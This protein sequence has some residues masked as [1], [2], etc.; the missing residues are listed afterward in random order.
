M[1]HLITID[2]AALILVGTHERGGLERELMDAAEMIEHT[3]PTD[4]TRLMRK[5]EER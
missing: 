3:H 4:I 1:I 2:D 5:A